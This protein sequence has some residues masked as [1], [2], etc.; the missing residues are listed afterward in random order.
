MISDIFTYHLSPITYHLTM[1]FLITD[2][3]HPSLIQ[4]LETLGY[5]CHYQPNITAVEVRTIIS[6]YQGLIINS[7]INVDK[8]LIDRATNLK[9]VGRVGSGME[10]VDIPYA[11]SKGIAVLS[12]PEGNRNAVAEHAVGMLLSLIN[13]MNRANNEV[14]N[15]NWRREENRGQE[16]LGKKIGIVGFGNTGSSFAAKLLGFGTEV[17]TYD[18]YLPKGY[19]KNFLPKNIVQKHFTAPQRSFVS[20]NIDTNTFNY[21]FSTYTESSLSDIQSHCD[22]ISFHLPLTAETKHF[23]NESFLN[24]CTESVILINTSRGNVIETNSLISALKNKKVQGACLDVFENEK[25]NTFSPTE[26][27]MYC[28]L[29]SYENVV[30]SPHVAGWTIESKQRL[31]EILLDKIKTKLTKP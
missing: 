23:V 2:D 3:V 19:L 11:H 10:I 22:I 24:S 5:E 27:A 29:Y 21:N 6:D 14:K 18:K 15:F 12:S 13:N 4:G 28:E 26:R 31:A 9:F 17:L 30:V 16:L 20:D 8:T 25:V 7:K 1:K